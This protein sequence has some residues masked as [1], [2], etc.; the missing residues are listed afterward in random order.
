[1][2]DVVQLAPVAPSAD[3]GL[4]ELLRDLLARAEA[5]ELI[6]LVFAAEVTRGDVLR[7]ASLGKGGDLWRLIGAMRLL[8]HRLLTGFVNDG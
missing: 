3:P 7:A 1:V 5:G 4:V 2:S 6:G 8:E